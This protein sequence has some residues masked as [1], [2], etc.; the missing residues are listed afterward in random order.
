[1]RRV[2]HCLPQSHKVGCPPLF[3][4]P[5]SPP[6]LFLFTS[7][8][9]LF[10]NALAQ[11]ATP[12][13]TDCFSGNTSLKLNVSTVYAQITTSQSLGRQ[14]NI[15]VLG[16]SPQIIQGTSN[17]SSDLGAS[18]L[19]PFHPLSP[20]SLDATQSSATLFSNTE[21][22]TFNVR[23][24]NS[25]FCQ[26]L[27]PPSP[28]PS[29]DNIT[30]LYCPIPAG[31][32][33]FSAYAPLSSSHELATLQT[34]LRAVDPFSNELLC[35]N[36]AT[37]LLHPGALGSVYG[38]ARYLFYGTVILCVVYWLLVAVARFS[39]AWAR[40]SGW[41][42]SGFWPRVENVGFV[43]ASAIS[44]EGLSKSP[45][46][47]RFGTSFIVW[48]SVMVRAR[49]DLTTPHSLVRP[50]TPSPQ[51]RRLCATSFFTRN[52]VL[53]LRWSQSNGQNSFVTTLSLLYQPS[54]LS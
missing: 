38:H 44:G 28:L 22:L 7:L 36:I 26:T 46:L 45:A 50:P 16:Q 54:C 40:R 21:I 25:Y 52:G 18:H 17:G 19:L 23:N 11:V 12:R 33:A 30:G 9:F 20:L 31:P 43:A 3:L 5:M 42:R 10:S 6:L 47:I 32:F 35:I 2:L 51:S 24:N 14:L 34:S 37:T 41:S 48:C 15:T 13:F 27:R 8:A 4:S 53:R 29:P 39:S 49:P 1:M